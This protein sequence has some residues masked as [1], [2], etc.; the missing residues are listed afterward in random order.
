MFES[1]DD[2]E[3]MIN[4]LPDNI[5][6]DYILAKEFADFIYRAHLRYNLILSKGQDVL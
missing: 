5:R 2:I 4:I 1:F 6:K 3:G